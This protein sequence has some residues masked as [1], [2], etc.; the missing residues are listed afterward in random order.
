MQPNYFKIYETIV[1]S[2]AYGMSTPTSDIDK[3]G[4]AIPHLDHILG[5]HPFEQHEITADYTI[6]SL[7]KFI[8]LASDCNPNIIEML[9]TD[10]SDITF[11]H[12]VGVLLRDNRELF[13]SSKIKFTF[14]GYAFSQLQRIKNHQRWINNPQVIPDKEDFMVRKILTHINGT[15]ETYTKFLEADYDAA[16]KKYVQYETWKKER[17]TV[18]AALENKIGYDSKH[19]AH[20]IRLLRMGKE[21]LT[22]GNVLVKRPDAEYLLNI[23]NGNV[24]YDTLVSEAEDL[25]KELDVLYETTILP[26][27]VDINKINALLIRIQKEFY[28]IK[29]NNESC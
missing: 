29:D 16:Y 4:I 8:R 1:G 5:L 14:S 25:M 26:K 7:Q 22:T 18:R 20:L 24:P 12:P 10:E 27:K 13:L 2:H 21:I 19:G 15:Q 23:R 6:F 17:N 28:N 9:Y 3:K 11:M